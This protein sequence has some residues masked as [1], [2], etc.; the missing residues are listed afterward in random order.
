M[1]ADQEYFWS[2]E[3]KNPRQSQS[4]DSHAGV[5]HQLASLKDKSIIVKTYY[6]WTGEDQ[7]TN[8]YLEKFDRNVMSKDLKPFVMYSMNKRRNW[9]IDKSDRVELMGQIQELHKGEDVMF[10][11]RVSMS[12]WEWQTIFRYEFYWNELKICTMHELDTY[13]DV[14]PEYKITSIDSIHGQHPNNFLAWNRTSS[15]TDSELIQNEKLQ[16]LEVGKRT[17]V[18]YHLIKPPENYMSVGKSNFRR[19]YHTYKGRQDAYWVRK[20]REKMITLDLRY[21]DF[22]DCDETEITMDNEIEIEIEQEKTKKQFYNWEDHIVEYFV[23]VKRKKKM[24]GNRI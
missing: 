13:A 1:E 17:V 19:Y 5:E 15:K 6:V 2:D 8:R 24:N 3:C 23:H 12:T 4:Y 9:E 22:S 11:E 10:L 21:E 7:F 18:A 20:N 14:K 16:N